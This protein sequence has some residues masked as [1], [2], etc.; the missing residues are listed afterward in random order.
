M[1]IEILI[2]TTLRVAIL[3]ALVLGASL[4][5]DKTNVMCYHNFCIT[6]FVI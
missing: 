4:G 1:F 6:H 5:L 2:T 3:T